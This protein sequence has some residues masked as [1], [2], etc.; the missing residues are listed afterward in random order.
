MSRTAASYAALLLIAG[1]SACGQVHA[2]PLT[3]CQGPYPQGRQIQV[4]R[5]DEMRPLQ[6]HLGDVINVGDPDPDRPPTVSGDPVLCRFGSGEADGPPGSRPIGWI[7]YA[8][9][10]RGV[11]RLTVV[12]LGHRA[13]TVTVQSAG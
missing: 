1:V 2:Q 10:H 8:A 12:P 6:V 9:I 7:S 3:A 5:N 4:E 11:E 13:Y